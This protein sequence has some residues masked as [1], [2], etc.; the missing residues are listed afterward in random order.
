MTALPRATSE[1]PDDAGSDFRLAVIDFRRAL[2]DLPED[3]RVAVFAA[4]A[5]DLV[6]TWSGTIIKIDLVDELFRVGTTTGVTGAL[7]Q[8]L[9]A[10]AF[11]QSGG[12]P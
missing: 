5:R 7:L 2:D 6:T 3:E 12:A 11:R 8:N 10:D 4:G 9:L 1:E